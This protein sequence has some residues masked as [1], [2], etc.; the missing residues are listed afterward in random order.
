MDPANDPIY[1]PGGVQRWH[2][3]IIQFAVQ[4][5]NDPNYERMRD[6]LRRYFFDEEGRI[7]RIGRSSVNGPSSPSFADI[8]FFVKEASALTEFSPIV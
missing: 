7:S 3:I 4:P 6:F 2:Q 8:I 1:L 5:K